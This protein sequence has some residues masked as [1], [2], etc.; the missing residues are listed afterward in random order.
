MRRLALDGRGRLSRRAL[1]LR[2]IFAALVPLLLVACG[3]RKPGPHPGETIFWRITSSDAQPSGCT[4]DPSF[5]SQIKPIAVDANTYLIYR[6][7]GQGKSATALDCTT[8]DTSSCQPSSSGVVYDIAGHELLFA[9]E[10]KTPIDKST[11]QLQSAETWD[12]TDQGTTLAITISDVL[13]LVDDATA[14]DK[15]ETQVKAQSPNGLGLQGCMVNYTLG[16][17][18]E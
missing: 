10:A 17:T 5:T 1:T 18:I 11:C 4:D 15:L 8:F 12:L 6:V 13:A 7:D 16:A 3:P 14:C 2:W 9:T